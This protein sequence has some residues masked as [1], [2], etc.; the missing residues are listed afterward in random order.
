MKS[1][2]KMVL[3][4]AA[5]TVMVVSLAAP[6]MA[7]EVQE[8][9]ADPPVKDPGIRLCD[10][11]PTECKISTDP[12]DDPD[13]HPVNKDPGGI[14]LCDIAPTACQDADDSKDDHSHNSGVHPE[15]NNPNPVKEDTPSSEGNTIIVV[16]CIDPDT[17]Q[18]VVCDSKDEKEKGQKDTLSEATQAEK[19]SEEI[20]TA[21]EDALAEKAATASGVPPSPEDGQGDDA[22]V[23]GCPG[24][25]EYD[26]DADTCLPDSFGFFDPLF[27]ETTLDSVGELVGWYGNFPA[28]FLKVTG[29]G[30]GLLLDDIGETLSNWGEE[31]G[32]PLGWPLE[33]L[34]AVSSFTGQVFSGVVGGLGQVVGY[35][36]DGVGEVIDA[37][38]NAAEDA[39]DEVS[40]WF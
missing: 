21:K 13:H 9:S 10:I 30:M 34:G 11:T 12:V 24:G 16:D 29:A 32:G 31:I 25:Y 17:H 15:A 1:M 22:T 35:A 33:G 4:G 5:V 20:T 40:S 28:D 19:F 36:S 6:A 8:Q 39:W 37:I 27:G 26:E 2:K 14:R 3:V 18:L 23:Y 7:A 38:G